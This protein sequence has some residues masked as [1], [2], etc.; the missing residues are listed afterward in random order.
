[1]LISAWLMA[2]SRRPRPCASRPRASS[3]AGSLGAAADLLLLARI[4]DL[5][6]HVDRAHPEAAILGIDFVDLHVLDDV[7]GLWVDHHRAARA[8][9]GPAGPDRHG[10]VGPSCSTIASTIAPMPSSP[11]AAMKS[12]VLPSPYASCQAATNSRFEPTSR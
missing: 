4:L 1:M 3:G 6:D 8:V 2:Q 9:V 11:A 7:A 12:G 10:A 5:R